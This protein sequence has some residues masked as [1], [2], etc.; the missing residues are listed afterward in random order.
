MGEKD[1]PWLIGL[2]FEYHDEPQD[3]K[4]GSRNQSNRED[5]NAT[6]DSQY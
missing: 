1:A 6:A 4:Y 5:E 3:Y 2:L